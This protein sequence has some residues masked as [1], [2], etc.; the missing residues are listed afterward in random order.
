[1]TPAMPD[2]L[3]LRNQT[4]QRETVQSISAPDA[5]HRPVS[6]SLMCYSTGTMATGLGASTPLSHSYSRHLIFM[7]L[8]LL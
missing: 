5:P 1:M 7:C 2:F 3:S 4:T 8:A 6:G